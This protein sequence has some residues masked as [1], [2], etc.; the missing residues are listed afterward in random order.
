MVRR[1]YEAYGKELFAHSLNDVNWGSRYYSDDEFLREK[2]LSALKK[3]IITGLREHSD[4]GKL[5][6]SVGIS[7][8]IDSSTAAWLVAQAM[9]NAKKEDV[10]KEAEIA[11]V[12]CTTTNLDD[13]DYG[14]LFI[15][16]FLSE[17]GKDL[18]VKIYAVSLTNIIK[19]LGDRIEITPSS[20]VKY[21]GRYSFPKVKKGKEE[22]ILSL[23]YLFISRGIKDEKG[24]SY[25]SIDTTDATEI[26]LGETVGSTSFCIAPFWNLYKS[27]IYD[28]AKT[29]GVPDY[30]IKRESLDSFSGIRK[31]ETYFAE[32]PSDL[33]D[34]DI[35]NVLDPVLYSIYTK[36]LDPLMI[37][38]KF[39]HSL[40]FVKRVYNHIQNVISSAVQ[41]FVPT[42]YLVEI[43]GHID[44]SEDKEVQKYY[45]RIFIDNVL[46]KKSN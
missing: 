14:K 17:F 22:V 42:S 3:F 21:E 27:Q 23:L 13:Y 44:E 9:R 40:D 46:I 24:R 30:V 37:A 7:G 4:D 36:G 41:V 12:Q 35:Y 18:D 25:C 33:T 34:K 20:T 8:G 43:K 26:I 5:R 6:A 16:D 19:W 1:M 38:Q 45:D 10:A 32:V 11:L 31:I 28:V 39:G 29:I 2:I 15:R